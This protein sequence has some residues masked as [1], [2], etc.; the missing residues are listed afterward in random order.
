MENA[1]VVESARYVARI[2]LDG[3]EGLG[4]VV[5]GHILTC[6]H[7]A[8]AVK[9]DRWNWLEVKGSTSM[10]EE[11]VFFVQTLDCLLDFMVLGDNPLW[12]EIDSDSWLEPVEPAIKPVRPVF[13]G[14]RPAVRTPVYFFSPD[15]C[16]PIFAT[17]T[18]YR[19]SPWMVLD[20]PC[21]K[22]CSGGPV[23]TADHRLV[24]INQ[25]SFQ[26]HGA[27]PDQGHAIRI[28]QAATGWLCEELGGLDEWSVRGELI[29]A[30]EVD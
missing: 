13:P 11:T 17:A 28:D 29:K 9:I 20:Q 16:T 24:G 18:L 30:E 26:Y 4:V 3:N 14:D 25:G 1:R 6:A 5:P 15:G 7:F 10:Q 2:R 22:G 19:F 12:Q 23:F 21:A 27:Q 8:P